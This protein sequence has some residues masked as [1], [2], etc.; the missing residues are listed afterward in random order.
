MIAGITVRK[1]QP[2][3]DKIAKT[4]LQMASGSVRGVDT[5]WDGGCGAVGSSAIAHF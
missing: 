3:H 5:G 2:S 4:K 1:R